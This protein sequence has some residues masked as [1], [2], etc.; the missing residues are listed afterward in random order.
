MRRSSL[1]TVLLALAFQ[2]PAPAQGVKEALD[3]IPDDAL[4]FFLVNRL[5]QTNQKVEGLAKRYKLPT[6]ENPLAWL[7]AQ[8]GFNG[9]GSA[10]VLLFADAKGGEAGG[11]KGV[12]ICLPVTD[13]QAFATGLGG[14][15]TGKAA[16][17][18]IGPKG[19]GMRVVMARKGSFA[20]VA[21]T[22]HKDLLAIAAKE[23]K[24]LGAWGAGL[25]AYLTE[26]DAAGALTPRGLKAVIGKAMMGLALAKEGI[27]GA[28][29]EA[30]FVGQW[31]EGLERFLK[32]VESDVT[33]VAAGVRLD[34]DN[35]LQVG[36]RSLFAK[37]SGF[38]KAGAGIKGLPEGPLSGL[39]AGPFAIAG[40]GTYD[41]KTLQ[42]LMDLNLQMFKVAAKDLPAE[43]L[44]GLEDAYAMMGKGLRGT[45]LVFQI[46]K[47]GDPLLTK[48][49]GVIHVDNA[50]DY[51]ERYAKGTEKMSALFQ[52]LKL[53]GTPT[54]EVKKVKI[55]GKP[56]V[57]TIMDF[58]GG[59]PLPDEAKAV[60]EKLL[61]PGGKMTVS[62]VVLDDKTILMRYT[63]GDGLKELLEAKGAKGGLA[64]DPDVVKT[65]ALLPEGSQWALYI[66]PQG[67]A[68][69]IDQVVRAVAPMPL[70]IPEL[71]KT[72]PIG[73]G[74]KLDGSGIEVRAALP[75]Q[76]LDVLAQF[77]IID[78][79]ERR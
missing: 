8:K 32:T 48:L 46:G 13:Y 27:A 62:Q 40:G 24:G 23:G 54:Q 10:A 39:P 57:E 41:E 53:P 66:H 59:Q 19:K 16:E 31:L 35:N 4:G 51:L 44:K 12:V 5:E 28:P 77:L 42:A 43:K 76:V 50:M 34:K 65:A 25:E 70:P 74:V 9:K 14:D 61:G 11:D 6:D 20:L 64:A 45:G 15:P 36:M 30:Q 63:A 56:G 67:T 26:N 72:P 79:V 75:A 71:P 3:V 69:M 2:V 18:Q 29:P 78:K 33:H 38:A 52:D 22:E 17:V 60:L 68:Q 58:A 21:D 37:G 73:V 47:E 7:L 49:A 55:N 1:W